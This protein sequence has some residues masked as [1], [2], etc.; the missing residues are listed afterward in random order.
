[1]VAGTWHTVANSRVPSPH[2]LEHG[3]GIRVCFV[4]EGARLSRSGSSADIWRMGVL[5]HYIVSADLE[6]HQPP[7][8]P[9]PSRR[10]L[11]ER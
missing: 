8:E 2:A 10:H 3:P 7:I 4:R 5:S 6:L 9:R 11:R 1:M